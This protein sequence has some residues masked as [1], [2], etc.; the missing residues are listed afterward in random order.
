MTIIALTILQR[1]HISFSHV[2]TMNTLIEKNLFCVMHV[3]DCPFVL[4]HWNTGYLMLA[5]LHRNSFH[6]VFWAVEK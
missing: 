5:D 6:A 1:T 2:S 3:T 4:K